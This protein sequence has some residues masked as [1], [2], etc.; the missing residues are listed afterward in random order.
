RETDL[1]AS[2]TSLRREL[3]CC[4]ARLDARRT[5]LN[6]HLEKVRE[7]DTERRLGEE[8]LESAGREMIRTQE[9][10]KASDARRRDLEDELEVLERS[11]SEA[12]PEL[13]RAVEQLEQVR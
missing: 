9:E 13:E 10:R 8:R 7:L 5:D 2:L 11:L 3:E 6:A 1:E 4:E 12:E